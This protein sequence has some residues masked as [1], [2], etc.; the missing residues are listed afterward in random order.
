M[1]RKL[2]RATAG[3]A[4][5]AALAAAVT[6]T[7]AGTASA[8]TTNYSTGDITLSCGFPAIGQQPVTLKASFDAPDSAA[9]GTVITPANVKATATISATLHTLLTNLGYNGIDGKAN[10]NVTTVGLTPASASLSNL[11]IPSQTY[12]PGGSLVVNIDQTGAS[13]PSFTVSGA[14]GT[15]ATVT[16]GGTFTAPVNL[17]KTNG[18]APTPWTFNCTVKS[19]ATAFSPSMP[20]T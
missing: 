4:T 14:S 11:D 16:I 19:G 20:I 1:S 15:Q 13:I 7:A 12:P 3:I 9:P 5:T 10:A 18:S 8:A 6:M 2:G 17:H